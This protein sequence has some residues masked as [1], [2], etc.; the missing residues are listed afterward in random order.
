MANRK[1]LCTGLSYSER[2]C[3]PDSANPTLFNRN[4]EWV[5]TRCVVLPINFPEASEKF[6][7]NKPEHT[8]GR[9]KVNENVKCKDLQWGLFSK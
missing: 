8:L 1:Q 3:D 7:K 6:L 4:K 9:Y 2:V 5:N